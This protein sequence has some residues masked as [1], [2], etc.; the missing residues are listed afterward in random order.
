[1][2]GHTLKYYKSLPD[3]PH[4]RVEVN[5]LATEIKRSI[6]SNE[7]LPPELK[8]LTRAT[9]KLKALAAIAYVYN[10]ATTHELAGEGLTINDI[11]LYSTAVK[12]VM[13]KAGVKDTTVRS[14]LKKLVDDG[15]IKTEVR[16]ENGKLET[17]YVVEDAG[18]SL[19]LST[20]IHSVYNDKKVDQKVAEVK[21][22]KIQQRKLKALGDLAATILA[23]SDVDENGYLVIKLSELKELADEAGVEITYEVIEEI[24][25]KGRVGGFTRVRVIDDIGIETISVGDVA[26]RPF[27]TL[28]KVRG[29]VIANNVEPIKRFVYAR[30]VSDDGDVFERFYDYI[31]DTQ[32]E[33]RVKEKVEENGE[34]FKVEAELD[35]REDVPVTILKLI[36]EAGEKSILVYTY[37]LTDVKIGDDVEIIGFVDQELRKNKRTGLAHQG[38]TIVRAYSVK[39]TNDVNIEFD[40]EDIKKFKEFAENN[41]VLEALVDSLGVTEDQRLAAKLALITLVSEKGFIDEGGSQNRKHIHMLMI[42][43]AGTGKSTLMRTLANVLSLE[44][45]VDAPAASAPGLLAAVKQDA[46]LGYYVEAGLLPR[47]NK[48]MGVFIDELDKAGYELQNTM[49]KVLEDGQVVIEKA[50]KGKFPALTSVIAAAN[51]IEEI[52]ETKHIFE[53]VKIMSTFLDRFDIIIVLKK[54]DLEVMKRV[55]EQIIKKMISDLEPIEEI[56]EQPMDRKFTR[57]YIYY[58]YYYHKLRRFDLEAYKLIKKFADAYTTIKTK[59][60]Q[61]KRHDTAIVRIARAIARIKLHEVVTIDDAMEAIKLYIMTQATLLPVDEREKLKEL[62]E[63]SQDPESLA[64]VL[65]LVEDEGDEARVRFVRRQVISLLKEEVSKM[66]LRHRDGV[67]IKVLAKGITQKLGDV[68][69]DTVLDILKNLTEEELAEV[70]AEYLDGKGNTIMA[71][72]DPDNKV[73]IAPIYPEEDFEELE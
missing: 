1:M 44:P 67:L 24:E 31:Y 19:I 12:E 40:E 7:M 63:A 37:Q 2:S 30:F 16:I 48:K 69:E 56:T 60:Q 14:T 46:R 51:P 5:A 28:V 13:K 43:E 35:R 15:I 39:R 54:P 11:A 36:D 25:R 9:S 18:V 62:I 57:D 3:G 55:N 17:Y 33:E 27:H 73:Y 41:D 6:E 58:V 22:E 42:S 23:A 59:N 10:Y 68:S 61:S 29:R 66:V 21:G 47:N 20:A 52:D 49:H 72:A 64:K 8:K 38:R 4:T 50:G 65:G 45:P 70:G 53:Q 71:D 32:I 34:V 26:V